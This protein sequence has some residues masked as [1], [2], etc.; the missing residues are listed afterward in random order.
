MKKISILALTLLS[1]ESFADT[2]MVPTENPDLKQYAEFEINDAEINSETLSF[3]LPAELGSS[4]M[5]RVTFERSDLIPNTY[6]STFGTAHCLQISED[7]LSC[8]VKY[9]NIYKQLLTDFL[10]ETESQ[11]EQRISSA[12]EL[13]NRIDLAREFST[14]PIG[15]LNLDLNRY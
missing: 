6:T 14:E 4:H 5:R 12:Q 11:L 1:L 15:F 10:P 2:Y 9:N 3:T 13:A 7:D 8:Q